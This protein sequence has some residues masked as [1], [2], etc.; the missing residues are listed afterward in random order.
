MSHTELCIPYSGAR[1]P[2]PYGTDAQSDTPSAAQVRGGRGKGPE[3]QPDSQINN[4]QRPGG[5]QNLGNKITGRPSS[6]VLAP[7]GGKSQITFG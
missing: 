7:P 3:R 5:N 1:T 6:K 4:Y 2:A